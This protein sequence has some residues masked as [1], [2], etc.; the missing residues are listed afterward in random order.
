MASGGGIQHDIVADALVEPTLEMHTGPFHVGVFTNLRKNSFEF[1]VVFKDRVGALVHGFNGNSE[2][3]GIISA[4]E[5]GL[6]GSDELVERGKLGGR[7]ISGHK[8]AFSRI[9]KKGCCSLR[10]LCFISGGSNI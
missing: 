7:C 10:F 5:A 6:E 3:A 9:S 4:C 1:S 2:T 8:S